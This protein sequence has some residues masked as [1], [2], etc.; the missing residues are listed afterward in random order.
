MDRVAEVRF[1][2]WHT[3]V[4]VPMNCNGCTAVDVMLFCKTSRFYA[5]GS[6]RGALECGPNCERVPWGNSPMVFP[7]PDQKL[8]SEASTTI[9]LGFLPE[10]G[11]GFVT[12]NGGLRQ[13]FFARVVGPYDATPV[14]ISLMSSKNGLF[15]VNWGQAPFAFKVRC[16]LLAVT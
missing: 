4:S 7:P 16:D 1:G 14:V 8:F 10:F 3:M 15:G 13:G 9:G 2:C 11:F 12:I 5:H 6:S